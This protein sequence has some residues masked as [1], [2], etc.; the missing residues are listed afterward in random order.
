DNENPLP[1]TVHP[2]T[3]E[4]DRSLSRQLTER[5]RAGGQAV[6]LKA[7]IADLDESESLM[8]FQDAICVPLMAD[9][10]PLGALHVYKSGCTFT[11]AHVRFCELIAGYAAAPLDRLRQCRSLRAENKR[12]RGRAPVSEE[13]IGNSPAI[14]Q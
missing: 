7:G 8:P 6:W 5:V 4:F 9:D 12:L 11:E 2:E 1:R 14:R 3:A 13:I 10:T